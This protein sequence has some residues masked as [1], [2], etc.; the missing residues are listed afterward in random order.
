MT[1]LDDDDLDGV[2]T[3][4]GL[5]VDIYPEG[6][7]CIV[8][9]SQERIQVSFSR[10][11]RLPLQD[12][13][14][15]Y[16]LN[17]VSIDYGVR[18]ANMLRIEETH[19]PFDVSVATRAGVLLIDRDPREAGGAEMLLLS[20]INTKVFREFIQALGSCVF[21]TR[22]LEYL[23]L[24]Q[25]SCANWSANERAAA[26]GGRFENTTD[27]RTI[28]SSKRVQQGWKALPLL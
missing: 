14:N 26:R 13:Y 12:A 19:A 9:A 3:V 6:V 17:W 10:F 8:T 5:V 25:A 11:D 23:A 16:L 22:L 27:Q 4:E 18:D 1:T 21:A 7:L 20:N 28:R 2:Q 24:P 15:R